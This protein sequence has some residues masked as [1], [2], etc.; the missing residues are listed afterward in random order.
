MQ[1][2]VE[3][4]GISDQIQQFMVGR[5]SS[6]SVSH[7][8]VPSHMFTHLNNSHDLPSQ[9]KHRNLTHMQQQQ[10]QQQ[11]GPGL[12]T[13]QQLGLQP[14]DS[15][16]NRHSPRTNLKQKI[17]AKEGFTDEDISG[18]GE[19]GERSSEANRWPREET[20][21][22][23]RI[24]SLMD[25]NF[26]DSNV[27]GPVWE[28]VSR[29][30]ADLGFYRSAK[31][32]KEKFEN[33]NKY[34]RKTKD[35]RINRQDGKSYKFFGEL[36]ALY[37]GISQKN[38]GINN[39]ANAHE[40][41]RGSINQGGI[42]NGNASVSPADNMNPQT[43]PSMQRSTE[44]GYNRRLNSS[45]DGTSEDEFEEPCSHDAAKTDQSNRKKRK[46]KQNL[47]SIKAFLENMVKQTMDHQ[48]TLQKKFLEAIEKRDQER[49]MREEAWKR[50]EMARLNRETEQRAQEHALASSREEAILGFLQKITG[51]KLKI[52]TQTGPF[53]SSIV[54]V[55]NCQED[56]SNGKEIYDPHC[57]R[58]P[59]PEVYALIKL[60]SSMEHRFKEPGPKASLWEEISSRMACMG[61]NRSAKRCKE[62]WE[63][64]N[65]YFRKTKGN[66]KK[67]PLNSKTCPYFHQ[68]DILYRKGVLFSPAHDKSNS[69]LE[70]HSI[71]NTLP[72]ADEDGNER[73]DEDM[74][75]NH[76]DSELLAI[77]P[78][79][80]QGSEP[81]ANNDET[82]QL[83]AE[84]RMQNLNQSLLENVIQTAD[85]SAALNSRSTDISDSNNSS[86][87]IKMERLVKEMMEMQQNQQQKILDEF[88][89]REQEQDLRD[90]EIHHHHQQQVVLKSTEEQRS[91]TA[92]MALVH[93]L[94]TNYSISAPSNTH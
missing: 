94:A 89:K 21:A 3:Y 52:E 49:L 62:K 55:P 31:K 29:K 19:Q 85:N 20:L 46:R 53:A 17:Q 56:Q 42:G 15:P 92:L 79:A 6:V 10:Q 40:A 78:D 86:K 74:Q 32:C 58:W 8:R 5:G 4:N 9:A 27:K 14:P 45:S 84:K 51:E 44:A 25:A 34:Y 73:L 2:G 47:G 64:I 57:K 87:R 66:M 72:D 39:G 61:F 37:A 22:L 59:K 76:E 7:V 88:E 68:L 16:Q 91:Q 80:S 38:G 41:S 36:E 28:T 71:S 30:L 54:S 23:L 26:R 50:Q 33:V 82:R 69:K 35:G 24:R 60:R 90:N 81:Q 83:L 18:V 67:R 70:N 12:Q 48:E 77:I 43:K 1:S 13:V 63:N 93:K 75:A 11:L 65:K